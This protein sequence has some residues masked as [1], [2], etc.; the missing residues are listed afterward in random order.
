MVIFT[1][2][3][4]FISEPVLVLILILVFFNDLYSLHFNNDLPIY[5][6]FITS[7]DQA[8]GNKEAFKKRS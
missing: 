5:T 7:Q 1:V 4:S 3:S 6:E 2:C 8:I